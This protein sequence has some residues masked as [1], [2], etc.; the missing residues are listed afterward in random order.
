MSEPNEININGVMQA[1]KRSSVRVL[2]FSLLVA[3]G[4]FL[5][6]S[7]MAPRYLSE[8]RVLVS[9]VA[10][11][12][13]PAAGRDLASANNIDI[14][15]ILSQIQVIQSRDIIAKVIEERALLEDEAFQAGVSKGRSGML[16]ALLPMDK[17]DE[18]G[19]LPRETRRQITIDTILDN[20]QVISLSQSRVLAIRYKS[21]NP[22]SA[23][24]IANSLAAAY[25][26]WQRSETVTQNQDD[27][28]RL[29]RLIEDL[30]KEVKRTEAAVADYR[31]KK[32]IYKTN[33]DNVTL[34]R[35]Q[36]TELNSRI[37]AARERRADSEIRA[38]LIREMLNRDGEVSAAPDVMRSEL[39]NG[40]FEQKTRVHRTMS[41]LGATLLPS[42]PRLQQLRSEL[43]GINRQIR[44]AMTRIV[45]AMEN[46]AKIAKA[47]EDALQQSLT[48]LKNLS[49]RADGDEIQLRALEREANTNRDLLNTYLTRLRDAE[50]RKE[51][52]IAPSYASIV[53]KAHVP[54]EPFFP[55]V[56]PLTALA[57]LISFLTGL[58]FVILKALI[59]GMDDENAATGREQ[60][61]EP[62]TKKVSTLKMEEAES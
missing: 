32:G 34:D 20:L 15:T 8:S 12:Q 45:E 44:S 22:T 33:R 16:A 57:F 62:E 35:Q 54:T 24:D 38:R 9:P 6:F 28:I 55:R 51:S 14:T 4:L 19:Q 50:A 13:D 61:S 58:G 18:Y 39:M 10:G 48:E 36:L 2:I 37:I 46:D 5:L 60:N 26:N 43:R 21:E 3:G 47:R 53:S 29:A 49:N 23:A 1:V 11:Y 27:S 56:L 52:A 25:I 59:T 31:A 41:E 7:Q 40:L 30:K 42:H 17:G